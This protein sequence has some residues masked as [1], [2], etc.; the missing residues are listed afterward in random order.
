MNFVI[1]FALVQAFVSIGKVLTFV[2][3]LIEKIGGCAI[4]V[5]D[6]LF[7]GKNWARKEI[8]NG[9]SLQNHSKFGTDKLLNKVSIKK[10]ELF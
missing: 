8:R 6:W 7:Q 10:S 4:L 1:I 5:I 2:T 9:Q 3:R